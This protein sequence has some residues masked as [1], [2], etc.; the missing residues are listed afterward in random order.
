MEVLM[1]KFRVK[2]STKKRL[3]MRN[4]RDVRRETGVMKLALSQVME[5][6][7]SLV[8]L[9]ENSAKLENI[10]NPEENIDALRRSLGEDPAQVLVNLEKDRKEI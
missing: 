8:N 1:K 4:V 2:S 7:I 5:G 9:K 3:T 10:Q 6:S